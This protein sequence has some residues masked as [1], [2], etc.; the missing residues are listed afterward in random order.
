M[1]NSSSL[2]DRRQS[3][4]VVAEQLLQIGLTPDFSPL[5]AVPEA[6]F[7]GFDVSTDGV[8]PAG[9]DAVEDGDDLLC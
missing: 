9:A 4:V 8:T 3:G 1:H 6:L 5:P 2:A 7:G